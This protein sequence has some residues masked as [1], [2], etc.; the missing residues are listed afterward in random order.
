M[1][2]DSK[3]ERQLPPDRKTLRQVLCHCMNNITRAGSC[4]R[5]EVGKF[6]ERSEVQVR[7]ELIRQ[8]GLLH[9]DAL[10]KIARL[11]DIGA[12]TDGHLVSKQLQ[13][14]CKNHRSQKMAGLRSDH[15][16]LDIALDS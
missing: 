16:A 7:I 9:G 10:G 5:K 3:R 11:I 8:L 4:R 1:R 12:A 14:Y 2:A 6:L 13:R 15:H